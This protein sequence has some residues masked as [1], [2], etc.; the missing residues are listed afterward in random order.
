MQACRRT[1]FAAVVATLLASPAAAYSLIPAFLQGQRPI[2]M[3][4]GRFRSETLARGAPGGLQLAVMKRHVSKGA[5]QS[6]GAGPVA[7]GKLL[8]KLGK[9]QDVTR[10]RRGDV[11]G[12]RGAV[13][14]QGKR[15]A[16]TCLS[17]LSSDS[18]RLIMR[19]P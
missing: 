3:P 18:L 5:A 16:T 17:V 7:D 19:F 12:A 14:V 8:P 2:Y 11:L 6:D 9:L 13:K 4:A 10:Q 1:A 15:Y